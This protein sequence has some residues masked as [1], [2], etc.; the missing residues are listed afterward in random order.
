[1]SWCFSILFFQ[2]T[3]ALN[4][5]FNEMTEIHEFNS[6][7]Y[8]VTAGKWLTLIPV[9][10]NLQRS[11]P[12]T[13]LS[14]F[15]M[16]IS[17]YEFVGSLDSLANSPSMGGQQ[18]VLSVSWYIIALSRGLGY[19]IVRMYYLVLGPT[20]FREFAQAVAQTSQIFRSCQLSGKN[21]LEYLR[22][23]RTIKWLIL[24]GLIMLGTSRGIRI[25]IKQIIVC[26][27]N[28]ETFMRAMKGFIPSWI[29]NQWIHQ[30][31]L[32]AKTLYYTFLLVQAIWMHGIVFEL[33]HGFLL[34]LAV[35]PLLIT[36]RHI[37]NLIR[38]GASLAQVRALLIASNSLSKSINRILFPMFLV[39][40]LLQAL[41]TILM[42]FY[43]IN[44]RLKF[45]LETGLQYTSAITKALFFIQTYMLA[46][47]VEE[48]VRLAFVGSL[49]WR[50]HCG[51]KKS[52][53][54]SNSV[55]N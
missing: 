51:E 4:Y 22:R 35:Y 37:R 27:E 15:L 8:L 10:K 3:G 18:A 40:L 48:E 26:I 41:V 16:L 54:I 32:L 19:W 14:G 12:V 46:T 30:F 29:S 39:V 47:Q 33:L 1:M 31:P 34:V 50:M 52:S 23:S 28:E 9:R 44:A 20:I 17:F 5:R 45:D 11:W 36:L 21:Y 6:V 38:E 42:V 24:F 2:S 55:H 49:R 7:T 43:I 53:S 13:I 25:S